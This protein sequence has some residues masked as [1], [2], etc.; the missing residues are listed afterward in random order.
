[1]GYIRNHTII[2]EA[3]YG[4][5]IERAHAKA[6]EIFG[7]WVSPITPESVNGS[8]AF[9]VPPDGSKEGWGE[10]A[11]G[12]ERRERF[13]AWLREQAYEDHS[14]PLDWVEVR[15]GG[16]DHDAEIVDDAHIVYRS[17][18]VAYQPADGGVTLKSQSHAK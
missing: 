13:K 16:D 17:A 9:F 18:N 4:D 10:S 7:K 8:R 2:V 12:D 1:M 14:T 6:L 3:S 5:H 11:N 15:F